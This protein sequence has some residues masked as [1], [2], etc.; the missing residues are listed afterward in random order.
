MSIGFQ[1]SLTHKFRAVVLASTL[2]ALVVALGA[3]LAFDLRDARRERAADLAAQAALLAEASAAPLQA[4]DR[5]G[6]E[7]GLAALRRQPAVRTAA[8][9]DGAGRLVAGYAADAAEPPPP[10]RPAAAAA[11]AGD[12]LLVVQPVVRDGQSVGS[13][14]LRA[15][16]DTPGAL[17]R[18]AG[19]ALSAAL[20]A[21]AAAWAVSSWL[22]ARVTRPVLALAATAREAVRRR[23][24]SRRA[25][26]V[27]GDEVG[28]LAD[29]VNE[30][31]G[32][33]ERREEAIGTA[34]AGKAREVEERRAIQR[35]VMRL[36]EELERRVHERTAQLEEANR[37]LQAATRDAE[38]ANRAKSDFLS[39]MS[40]EL[41]TPLNAIIGFGQLLQADGLAPQSLERNQGFIGHIVAA[42]QH[43]LA[44]INDILNLAQIEAGKMAIGLETIELAEVLQ[45]CHALT[46]TASAQ[47]G[48]RLL[49][50]LATPLRVQAD[51]TRLKQVLLNLLS[52]A[53]KYNRQHGAVIVECARG[54]ED[55]VRISIQDTGAGLTPEQVRGLFQPFNRLGRDATI[56]G[57]G[58]G[59]VLT[60]RLVELMGGTIGVT[61]DPGKGS[62]F[63]IDLRAAPGDAGRD[64]DVPLLTDRADDRPVPRPSATILCVD[65]NR[66]N[67]ALLTEA[68]ALR[69]DCHVLT[70][71]DGQ[72]GVE[73]ARS[74]RPDV[75]LMDNNMPVMSGREAM[76]VLRAD[77]VTA[78]IPV[79]AVSAAAM[80]DSV[81]DGIE[82]GY[83]RYLVKP[84]DLVDLTDAV[85]A[86]ID[87][88]KGA[89]ARARA[90][91]AA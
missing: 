85:D 75:I 19:L 74:Y 15:R 3:T 64:A 55:R 58:I 25:E 80:P 81:S 51:R 79:I 76:K 77:P 35:E 53:V 91:A 43:L 17:L 20:V 24:W 69:A 50:P 39:N 7:R 68:L 87:A 18:H 83:F 37:S 4:A 52:N 89:V 13:V 23:D 34:V 66:A 67:L 65:D 45:E 2:A 62:T 6:A 42:G 54:D 61:S 14:Y 48:L 46:Q 63:W 57:S 36:N 8:L 26:R 21:L 31:L 56:E 32:E 1:L 5:A 10:S 84:Y 22:Q 60:R 41:R 16:T 86:A 40:H 28:E 38:T 49:F 73:M 11:A 90:A 78:G 30:L 72:A 27:S 33:I 59:L 9:Y 88:R 29:A 12:T 70:A 47:R 71:A 44:L 82:Q